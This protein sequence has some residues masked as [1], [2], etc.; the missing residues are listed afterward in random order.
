MKK[1]LLPMAVMAVSLN[2]CIS[3]DFP[4]LN[5]SN[6]SQSTEYGFGTIRLGVDA[7][8]SVVVRDIS[9]VT[10]AELGAYNI[11]VK[12]GENIKKSGSYSELFGSANTMTLATGTGYTITAES[13]TKE[14]AAPDGEAGK[15]RYV[16][17]SDAFTVNAN[18]N[19]S[20]DVTC[21]IANAQVSIIWSDA[22]NNE[23][24]AFSD[25]KVIFNASD[26]PERQ[27]TS[28]Q[29]NN[30]NVEPYFNVGENTQ[31][32]GTISY[33][34]YGTEKAAA[35]TAIPLSAATHVKLTIGIDESNGQIT[36][37]V[38]KDDTVTDDNKSQNIN[39]YA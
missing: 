14:A 38:K 31:L 35:L 10:G 33:S 18:A 29:G 39:P 32:V 28:T 12:Q 27:F 7:D 9:D 3:E 23:N 37:T 24:S 30:S 2:A 26:K 16:G 22:F 4:E 25:C 20:V 13:C 1:L 8:N 19:T 15:A 17:T 6:Q 21:K 11:T 34:F 5:N 36:I